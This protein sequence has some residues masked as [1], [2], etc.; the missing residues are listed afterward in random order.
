MVCSWHLTEAL[1]ARFTAQQSDLLCS[2]KR[3]LQMNGKHQ[4]DCD[5]LLLTFELMRKNYGSSLLV[6]STKSL[7]HFSRDFESPSPW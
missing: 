4:C 6:D 7:L 2:R 1:N 3:L 5:E